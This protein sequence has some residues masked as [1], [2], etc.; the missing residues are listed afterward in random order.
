MMLPNRF[1]TN[2]NSRPDAFCKKGALKNFAKFAG[3]HLR[4]SLLSNEVAGLFLNDCFMAD[5]FLI[6][7]FIYWIKFI[8]LLDSSYD[9]G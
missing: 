9:S 4:Q 8:N 2:R 5:V 6:Y 3:K 7:K 1:T